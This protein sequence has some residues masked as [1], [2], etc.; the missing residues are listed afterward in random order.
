MGQVVLVEG[1][2]AAV[3]QAQFQGLHQRLC[4]QHQRAEPRTRVWAVR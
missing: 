4:H 3:V 1:T 2:G